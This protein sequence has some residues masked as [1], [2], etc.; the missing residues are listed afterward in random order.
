MSAA[1]AGRAS[2]LVVEDDAATGE[3]VRLL[4][5]MEGYT[6]T[7]AA[8]GAAGLE[9]AATRPAAIVLDRRL[10]DVDGLVVSQH[11]RERLGSSV[12]I[13]L[14]TADLDP[15]LAVA[16]R[17]AG[18]TLLMRKPFDPDA[19]LAWVASATATERSE[20]KASPLPR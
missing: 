1:P 12:P 2:I 9:R 19:L 3:M 5:Q 8:T 10:P 20:T 15:A 17:A 4:L 13:L 6:V 11:V 14:L 16:A 7:V 18:V